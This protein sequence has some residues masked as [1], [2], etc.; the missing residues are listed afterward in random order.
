MENQIARDFKNR[1]SQKEYPGA[2]GKGRVSYAGRRL[3]RL[4]R[5]TNV[6]PVQIGQDVHQ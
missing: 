2:K 6:R 3:I 4:L 1:V 5:V